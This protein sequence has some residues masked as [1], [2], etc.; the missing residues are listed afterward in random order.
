M[1]KTDT[2]LERLDQTRERLLVTIAPLPDEALQEPGAVGRWSVADLLAILTAWE[3]EL[4]TGL[5]RLDQGKKP[6]KLLAA[7]AQP[8]AYSTQRFVENQ[9]RDLDRIFDDFQRVR[10]QL[11]EWLPAFS[12]R[13]LTEPNRYR[14]LQGKSLAQLVE[15]TT[16]GHEARYIPALE[17][18][19]REWQE[20]HQAGEQ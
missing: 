4:I 3:A 11:E 7:L 9:G 12:E 14:G 13:D 10:L 8:E 2:I 15:E 18:F 16:Y 20:R 1:T 5:M 17:T 19:A 6:G